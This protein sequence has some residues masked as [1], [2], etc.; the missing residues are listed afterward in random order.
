MVVGMTNS[1]GRLASHARAPF[2]ALRRVTRKNK[3]A[4]SVRFTDVTSLDFLQ[5]E[6]GPTTVLQDDILAAVVRFLLW[7]IFALKL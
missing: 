7:P 6:N 3:Q 2:K 5:R 4:P 1:I